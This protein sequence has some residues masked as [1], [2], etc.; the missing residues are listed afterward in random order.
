MENRSLARRPRSVETFW[1]L[2]T[3]GHGSQLLPMMISD[4]WIFGNEKCAQ[5]LCLKQQVRLDL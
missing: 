2:D 4:G 3:I 5:V 1:P